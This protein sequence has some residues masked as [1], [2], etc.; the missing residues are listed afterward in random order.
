MFVGH[1]A[2]GFAA[3]AAANGLD[4]GRPLFPVAGW[5]RVRI[6]PG[7]TP[8]TPMT[9]DRYPW[10]HSLL[11]AVVWGVLAGLVYGRITR[12]RA[13]AVFAGLA[14]MSHRALGRVT[15]RPSLPAVRAAAFGANPLPVRVWWFDRHRVAPVGISCR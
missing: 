11:M 7:N 5:E 10:S 14:V 2:V 3:K 12:Y 6:D 4:P 15:H 1:L 13:G 8:F 9:F